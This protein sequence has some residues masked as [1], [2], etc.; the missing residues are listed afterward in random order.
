MLDKRFTKMKSIEDYMNNKE[1]I[2][3]YGDPSSDIVIVF[4]GSTKGPILEAMDLLKEK[5]I[6]AKLIHFSWIYPFDGKRIKDILDREKHLIDVEGNGTG[7]FAKILKQET[8]F[9]IKEKL[10]KI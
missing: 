5:G 4:F 1:T 3:V 7:Q 6:S 2:K 9:D 8:G 10:L